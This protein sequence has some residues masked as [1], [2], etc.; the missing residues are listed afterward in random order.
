MATDL[1]SLASLNMP[2]SIQ[3]AR[4]MATDHVSP[5]SLQMP[6]AIH[7]A[8]EE[9]NL[10][11]MLLEVCAYIDKV[12]NATT[13]I[14]K[15]SDNKHIQIT[16]CPRPP[17][18]LSRCCIHSPDGAYMHRNPHIVAVE[19]DLALIRVDVSACALDQ[20][21]YVYQA[22]DKSGKPSLTLL[23]PTPQYRCFLPKDIG[24]LRRPGKE[25]IVAGFRFLPLAHPWG[26]LTLCVYDSKR[27]DW[28]LYALSLSLQGRQEYGDK[29]FLHK[30]CKVVTIGGD[31]AGTMAFVDLWRGMLFCDVLRLEHEAA[32]QAQS[33][34]IPV[35][36][37]VSL[38]DELRRTA[39]LKSDARL[40]RDIAFLDGHLKCVDLA[41]RS[42]WIRPATTSGVWSQQY[43]ITS[44]KEIEVNNPRTN[45][46][47]GQRGVYRQSF[48]NLLVCQPVVGL[49]DDDAARILYFTVKVD[50]TD[51]EAAVL[52]VDMES[53]KILG[54]A[55]FF[56]R[57]EVI[58][59]N[60]VHTRLSRHFPISRC[61]GDSET[62][63]KGCSTKM[64]VKAR[65]H[66]D[67]ESVAEDGD[68]MALD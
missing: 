60:Y 57:Y 29:S 55:P 51:A 37:Y 30:N 61:T 22:S 21:Y 25:Y 10:S 65:E 49:Q 47:P 48:R 43:K 56:S 52:G 50:Q 44:F 41:S 64:K 26:G 42:L 36:G 1:V 59:F 68:A 67:S 24:M 2:R 31:A 8:A 12:E 16:F 39:K 7:G 34:T 63:S 6:A 45:L 62:V 23:P 28:K 13:A 40:Y 5:A 3:G 14:S 38:P 32:R 11:W 20:D 15:T 18:F 46:F 58:N 4:S 17:P 9:S 66:H 33:E 35:L 27:A 19:D 54:V 53:K